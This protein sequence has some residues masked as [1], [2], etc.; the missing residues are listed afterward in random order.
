MASGRVVHTTL[1][2]RAAA[3]F[4]YAAFDIPPP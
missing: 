4:A 2:A 1:S 3:D